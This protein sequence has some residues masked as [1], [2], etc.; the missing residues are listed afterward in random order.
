MIIPNAFGLA[1]VNNHTWAGW[2]VVTYWNAFVAI[3]EMN[4]KGTFFDARL[5]TKR[6]YPVARV[7]A[8]EPPQ[9]PG[10]DHVEA[11]RVTGLSASDSGT[12][13]ASRT[14]TPRPRSAASRFSTGKGAAHVPRAA[15]LHGAGMEY[16]QAERDRHRTI[17]KRTI[18]RP[19]Y[20]TAPLKGL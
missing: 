2:G 9:Q 12:A 17:S 7:P 11:R 20:R 10:P 18:T 15:A 3:T 19:Q 14:S 13:A 5:R 4:G 16:T 6:R 8:L 1:G